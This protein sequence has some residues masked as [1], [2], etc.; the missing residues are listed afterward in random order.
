M[1]Y[2]NLTS[3]STPPP[4]KTG[5]C[6]L[7]NRISFCGS[8]MDPNRNRV[9]KTPCASLSPCWVDDRD[10]DHLYKNNNIGDGPDLKKTCADKGDGFVC[11]RYCP[12]A[13]NP[14]L[15][16]TP[17]PGASNWTGSDQWGQMSNFGWGGCLGCR[18]KSECS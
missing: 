1:S 16:Y 14:V 15:P 13:T 3:L 17:W 2:N 18:P 9:P 10:R 6:T 4:C 8:P 7:G 12:A 11:N 5:S